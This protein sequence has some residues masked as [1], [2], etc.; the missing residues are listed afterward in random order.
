MKHGALP[1]FDL[2]TGDLNVIIE[3][4]RGCR[5]K[6]TYDEETGLFKLKKLLPA[7]M[8]FPFDFGFIPSTRGGDG[9]PVDVLI[10]TDESLFPG[11][12]VKARLIGGLKAQQVGKGKT[13]RNDRLL[14]VPVLP[15]GNDAPRSVQDLGEKLL[16]YI[17]EF[18]FS[19]QRI[20]GTEFKVLRVLKPKEAEKSVRQSV[21][22]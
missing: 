22:K 19:Y 8:V 11:C 10:I 13:E 1:T 3:T 20:E 5:T 12:L 6:Y 4:P 16:C 9:D 14:A 21:E 17:K 18:F 7:G 15:N 2:K